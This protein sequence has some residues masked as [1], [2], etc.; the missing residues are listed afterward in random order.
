MVHNARARWCGHL[1]LIEGTICVS[2]LSSTQWRAQPMS[3]AAFACAL[4][5]SY[6][7]Y[8]WGEYWRT[9]LQVPCSSRTGPQSAPASATSPGTRSFSCS[10]PTPTS[11]LAHIRPFSQRRLWKTSAVPLWPTSRSSRRVASSPMRCCLRRS[12]TKLPEAWHQ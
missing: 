10:S 11:S 8:V 2:A 6:V 4:T 1:L 5:G 12:K 7:S 3:L 9:W